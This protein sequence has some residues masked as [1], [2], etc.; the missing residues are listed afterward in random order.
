MCSGAKCVAERSWSR[1]CW[2]DELVR[3]EIGPAVHHAMAH[4]NGRGVNMLPDC[5][6]K[7]GESLA[8]RFVHTFAL[9]EGFSVGRLNV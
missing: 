4:G 2:R 8:L 5:H 7:S 9:D 6:R 3:A 1:T